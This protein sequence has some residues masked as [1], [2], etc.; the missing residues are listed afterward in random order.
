MNTEK[1][2]LIMGPL[3]GKGGRDLEA[4]FIADAIKTD[5]N[6]TFCSTINIQE[7]TD[8][9]AFGYTGT[10]LGLNKLVYEN[11]K[12]VKFVTDLRCA[13][14]KK[15]RPNYFHISSKLS[16][17]LLNLNKSKK[18]ELEKLIP[19]YEGIIICAQLHSDYI[20]YVVEIAHY[21]DIPV[22]FRTTGKVSTQKVN[23]NAPWLQQV[24]QF[25]FHSEMN[26]ARAGIL[27]T[28]HYSII[29]QCAFN[30][31]ALLKIPLLKKKKVSHFLSLGRLDTNK[32]NTLIVNAFKRVPEPELRLTIVG[33][34]PQK[35]QLKA[36]VAKD[37]RIS[38]LDAIPYDQLPQLYSSVDCIVIASLEE[39]GPLTGLEAMAAGRLMISS[40]VGAMPE[41]LPEHEFWFDEPD[42]L[43]QT[44]IEKI[45]DLTVDE[46]S[47]MSENM[48]NHYLQH[49]TKAKLQKS[50]LELVRHTISNNNAL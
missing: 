34:G 19:K 16:K 47:H 15:I 30:E 8:L 14:R 39:S 25:V 46:V 17:L 24:T 22:I 5:F 43:L 11:D 36:L 33:N 9:H 38:V 32:N 44:Q 31:S 4:A 23:L 42:V 6:L 49:Y 28:D 41:R 20:P 40:K 2:I 12:R 45:R 18:R 29:D 7:E 26:A 48:R 37:T 21:R 10:I 35:E 1:N 50:Y 27:G 3:G 13:F